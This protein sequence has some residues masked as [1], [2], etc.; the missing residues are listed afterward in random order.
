MKADDLLQWPV[1]ALD[2]AL[3][4]WWHKLPAP[5]PATLAVAFSGGA[6]STALLLA[7]L[8]LQH[9][10]AAMPAQRGDLPRKIMALHIHH[11]LQA[12]ADGFAAHCQQ[13][14]Q[15]LAVPCHV[16]HLALV[17]PSG[18]SVEAVART[19]R[20]AALAALA[21]QHGAQ[22]VLLGHHTDDQMETVLLALSRGAGVA[23]LAGMPWQFVRHGSVFARPLLDVPSADIRH[24]L[25]T[26][27]VPWLDDPTNADPRFTRNK[28]RHSLA[29]VLQQSMPHF[30]SGIVRSARLAAEA[31]YLLQTLAASD[32]QQIGNPPRIQ[33]L[34]QLD[35]ARQ[36]NV[37]RHWLK[38]AHQAIGSEAQIHALLD[39]IEN[40]T[41]RGHRIHTKVADGY[42][43]R[44]GEN[45]YWALL[46]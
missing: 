31:D 33:A 1:S 26:H 41:T 24:W 40:C 37:L 27:Q 3:L 21:Q 6:D 36:A 11:G 15:Q 10:I 45:L 22:A 30:R 42:V 8:R 12:A 7:A 25:Q 32:L 34:Q 5:R 29:P 28:L 9:G 14:C 13:V 20:Y 17:C 43:Q 16:Q 4:N 38:T 44:Q 23:G 46:Q 2:R 35:R 39:V 19:A 18:D